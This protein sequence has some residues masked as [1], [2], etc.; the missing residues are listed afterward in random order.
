MMKRNF[1]KKMV[2]KQIAKAIEEYENTRANSGN[3]GGSRPTNIGGI[4]ASNVKG[5][6]YKTFINCKPHPFNG[7]KGVVGLKCWFEKMEKVFEISKCAE[8]DK[9]ENYD[10]N[11]VLHNHRNPNLEQ[12]L[13]TLTLK[14]LLEIVK[15]NVTS[16]KYITLHDA[17]NMAREMVE[18]AVQ[19]RA[20]SIGT[21]VQREKNL[22][23]ER[24]RAR[25]YVM[26]TKNP[27]HNPNVVTYIAPATLGTSYEVELADGKVVSTNTILCGC[28]LA[29]FNHVFKIDLLSTRLVRIPLSNG[30][31][32]EIQ[33]GRPEKDLKLLSCI[34]VDEKKPKYIHVVRDFPEVFPDNLSGLPPVREIEF[35]I[36]LIPGALLV[37]KLH[38]N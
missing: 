24:A 31:I 4:V 2:K 19:G 25:A 23:N 26:E 15:E 20:A 30:E 21:S 14:G 1:V 11:R 35:H 9:R 34:K 18:Q 38:T 3:A 8:D 12:E 33:G 13:W 22:Q 17:I 27:Q 36:D 29:L 16:S 28:T 10:D 5:C 7:T 6:S 37:V 32:L